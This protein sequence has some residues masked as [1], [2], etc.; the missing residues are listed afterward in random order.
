MKPVTGSQ[1]LFKGAMILTV[2]ALVTKLLSAVYRVPFQ[3]IVG[4]IGFYIYQQVYP[5]YGIILI[6]STH[7]FPVVISKL[8]KER[9]AIGKRQEATRLLAISLFFLNLIG[10]GLFLSF[11]LGAQWLA[12]IMGDEQLANLFRIMAFPFLIFPFTSVFRGYFQGQGNMVPTAISQVGEQLIRVVTILLLS[13]I[14]IQA[15]YSL[16]TAGSGAVFGSVTGGLV[17]LVILGFFFFHSQ[18][19]TLMNVYRFKDLTKEAIPIIKTL[20]FQ[21][22][23]ISVSGMVLILLQLADS[24]NLYNILTT[25]VLTDDEAKVAKGV[26]D[27]GQPLIQ[28]GTVV[29]TS[30]ALSLVPAITGEKRKQQ[31]I[32]NV[33]IALQ[34]SLLV[35]AGAAIGLFSIIEPT[36]RMLFQDEQGS[37]VLGLLSLVILPGSIMITVIGILQGVNQ[38]LYPAVIVLFGFG[39]KFILNYCLVPFSA[40][41]G[42]AIAT[43]LAVFV[44]LVFL[45]VRLRKIMKQQILATGYIV[46]VL[47]AA[48]IMGVFLHFYLFLTDFLYLYS[49]HSRM[50]ATFQAL[51]AVAFGAVAYI[52]I[53]IKS[54]LLQEKELLMLPF[55]SKLLFLLPKK[56]GD[57]NK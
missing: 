21:G 44:M 8:Y 34:L 25:G 29:A 51:S 15:G 40:T 7:G 31:I 16:Y 14:F 46:K 41:N 39:L 1:D 43:L 20:M 28:L 38:S 45:V 11:F 23:A 52:V 12:S 47:M 2:A 9:I 56:T 32:H 36:N 42:A 30:M 35:G 19:R 50:I 48:G 54:K 4:D 24:L 27:R 37:F 5:F 6:L 18:D 55:G 26:F 17:G 53:V 49:V 13:F 3:N 57:D 22:F 33:R 10:L